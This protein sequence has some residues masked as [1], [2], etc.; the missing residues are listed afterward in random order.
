MAQISP[1][2]AR[3]EAKTCIHRN[4]DVASGVNLLGNLFVS[5]IP[6][7]T[8]KTNLLAIGRDLELAVCD[9]TGGTW[10]PVKDN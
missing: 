2:V 10:P 1:K 5:C 8:M 3:S 6:F 7:I 9:M 4:L